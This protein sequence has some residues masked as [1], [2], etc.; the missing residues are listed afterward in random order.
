[1]LELAGALNCAALC[2]QEL[3]RSE[4][5]SI[6]LRVNEDSDEGP[7]PLPLHVEVRALGA[8]VRGLEERCQEHKC[9]QVKNLDLAHEPLNPKPFRFDE[10]PS[11]HP[12]VGG[13]MNCSI[14]SSRAR[15]WPRSAPSPPSTSEPALPQVSPLTTDPSRLIL[16]G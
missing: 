5:Q 1:M 7:A 8:Y 12:S 6:M 14:S 2:S 13:F 3:A 16:S 10:Y 4:L 15:R 9:A 11:R